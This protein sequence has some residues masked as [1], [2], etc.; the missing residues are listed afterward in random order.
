MEKLQTLPSLDTPFCDCLEVVRCCQTLQK[1][2]LKQIKPLNGVTAT[3]LVYL[4]TVDF[5][6]TSSPLHYV[7]L[8]VKAESDVSATKLDQYFRAMNLHLACLPTWPD[9]LREYS[10]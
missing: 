5:I 4:G 10:D 3:H 9:K 2:H 7:T 8:C 1:L 6:L